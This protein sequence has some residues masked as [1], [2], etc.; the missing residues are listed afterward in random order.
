MTLMGTNLSV[1]ER[2]LGSVEHGNCMRRTGPQGKMVEVTVIV[3]TGLAR[4]TDW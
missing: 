1:E 2:N 3:F 4:V